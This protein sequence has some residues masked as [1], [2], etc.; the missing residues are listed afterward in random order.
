MA[1]ND[2]NG[3]KTPP[4]IPTEYGPVTEWCR[5]QAA[6]NMRNDPAKKSAVEDLIGVE[7]AK[8]QFPEAYE[9]E[10]ETQA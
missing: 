4:I 6:I 3:I 7:K 2:D 10:D 8:A 9:G 1:M 5:R